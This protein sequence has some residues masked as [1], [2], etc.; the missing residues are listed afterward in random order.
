MS[1]VY[2]YVLPVSHGPATTAL[3]NGKTC[4]TQP[5]EPFR[6]LVFGQSVRGKRRR[7]AGVQPGNARQYIR[8]G[9]V[10]ID[11]AGDV[12]AADVGF[13]LGNFTQGHAAAHIEFQR[14]VKGSV[15]GDAAAVPCVMICLARCGVM[16]VPFVNAL[17][18]AVEL[19]LAAVFTKVVTLYRVV[20]WWWWWA[21]GCKP[22]DTP[23]CR[24]PIARPGCR[25]AAACRRHFR[26]D[27][28]MP[29][30]LASSPTSVVMFML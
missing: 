6:I 1:A 3:D 17:T 19:E 15:A 14:A 12:G 2:W 27:P 25:S 11:Q 22:S 30:R 4:V 28:E 24:G 20:H 29:F 23:E 7:L 21:R 13:H 10:H 26:W 8:A 18:N 9:R 16:V 5:M